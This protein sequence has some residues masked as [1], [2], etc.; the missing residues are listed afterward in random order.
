ML[1]K[2]FN[3]KIFLIVCFVLGSVFVQSHNYEHH[4]F[5]ND[6]EAQDCLIYHLNNQ[7]ADNS[8]I[9]D[10]NLLFNILAINFDYKIF[11]SHKLNIFQFSP[12]RA[13]PKL[14]F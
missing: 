6:C 10:M 3:K 7:I 4:L 8:L 14:F 1:A 12:I 5:S 13:P 9:L 11:V 2:I